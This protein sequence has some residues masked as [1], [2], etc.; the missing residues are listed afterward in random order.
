M[1]F[2]LSARQVHLVDGHILKAVLT[3]RDGESRDA[4]LDLNDIIGN[5][6]GW[7]M[8]EGVNFSQMA[9]DIKLEGS[10]LSAQLPKRDGGYIER[11]RIELNDRI[12]NEDGVLVFL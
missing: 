7:F 2:L 4:E 6:D 8:W 3:K 12:S 9:S 11:Q 10:V 1:P 5:T